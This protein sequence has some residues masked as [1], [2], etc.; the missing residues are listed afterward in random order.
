M[1][2]YLEITS[3]SAYPSRPAPGSRV[4][5]TAIYHNKSS[6]LFTAYVPCYYVYGYFNL[7]ALA[8]SG[9]SNNFNIEPGATRTV[10]YEFTMPSELV[11]V[12]VQARFY[13]GSIYQL[14]E[15]KSISITPGEVEYVFTIGTPTVRTA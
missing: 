11:T 5:I 13:N 1:A 12:T 4:V 8:M 2:T 9:Y 6:V 7:E 15:Q 14:D 10:Q 3:L